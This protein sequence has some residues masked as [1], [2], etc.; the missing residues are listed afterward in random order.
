MQVY[1]GDTGS[2]KIIKILQQLGWG[3]IVITRTIKLYSGEPWGFDNGAFIQW[4][5]GEKWSDSKFLKRL[6]LAMS[7]GTPTIAVTP[8]IV[9]KGEE[10]L[11]FSLKWIHRL[12]KWPW[13]I[14]IQ[15]GMTPNMVY[16]Y[17][18]LFSGIFMGGTN[19]FRKTAPIWAKLAHNAGKKF[20]LGRC[21]ESHL[22]LAEKCKAD[23]VDSCGP[24]WEE[25]KIHSFIN[26]YKNRKQSLFM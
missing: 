13:Y 23:S 3:R 19:T 6:D 25:T 2:S 11:A 9:A 21:N 24:L 8:D 22:K 18:E 1:L 12:P 17:I 7:M 10:S 15:D 20:H 16:P 26:A 4:R 5:Q 14:A